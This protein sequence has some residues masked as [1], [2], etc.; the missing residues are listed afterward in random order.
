MYPHERSLVKKLADKPFAL[1]GVNS[2]TDLE[3]I[4]EIIKTK[5]IPWR[6]F[7]CGEEGAAGSIPAEWRVST[8][9]AIYLIDA[10]GVIRYKNPADIDEALTALLAE[11]GHEVELGDHA[12]E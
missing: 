5:N 7:W 12:A 10:D 2:D 6:S 11:M 8:W 4:Q 1:I 9:P 3:Q